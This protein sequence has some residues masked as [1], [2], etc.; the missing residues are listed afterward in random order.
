[1]AGGLGV[2]EYFF[3]KTQNLFFFVLGGVGGGGRRAR[4]SEFSL[5]RIQIENNFKKIFLGAG[6]GGG[7][8]L[9]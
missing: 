3:T 9:V 5:F 4:V 7:T 1:M 6:G 8:G 2:S